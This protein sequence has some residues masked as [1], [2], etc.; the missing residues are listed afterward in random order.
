MT[1]QHTNFKTISSE[2]QNYDFSNKSLKKVS[3]LVILSI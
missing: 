1:T 3:Y 2:T